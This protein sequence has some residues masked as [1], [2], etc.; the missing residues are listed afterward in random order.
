VGREGGKAHSK[1]NRTPSKS[2]RRVFVKEKEGY[3]VLAVLVSLG[4]RGG[5][6]ADQKKKRASI[7]MQALIGAGMEK[8]WIPKKE[9]KKSGTSSREERRSKPHFEAGQQNA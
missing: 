6:M 1:E 4:E 2:K 7:P 9:G 3:F 5:E 8:D